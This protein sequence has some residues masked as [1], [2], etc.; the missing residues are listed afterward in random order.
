MRIDTYNTCS[1]LMLVISTTETTRNRHPLCLK[2]RPPSPAKSFCSLVAAGQLAQMMRGSYYRS[3][4]KLHL[5]ASAALHDSAVVVDVDL[6]GLQVAIVDAQHHLPRVHVQPQHP[7]QLCT[8][9]P[10]HLNVRLLALQCSCIVQ[11]IHDEQQSPAC[12]F[13]IV[14]LL[15]SRHGL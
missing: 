1:W 7:L 10:P 4:R 15:C 5:L 11:H 6:E 9:Q 3:K 14:A 8:T 13:K 12:P 2:G